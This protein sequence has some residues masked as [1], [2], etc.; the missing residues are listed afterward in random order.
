M[1]LIAAFIFSA[2][3]TGPLLIYFA[4]TEILPFICEYITRDLSQET[5]SQSAEDKRLRYVNRLNALKQETGR[6]VTR[7][8]SSLQVHQMSVSTYIY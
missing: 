2:R 8:F 7:M 6:S 3:E 5:L 4:L 1:Y